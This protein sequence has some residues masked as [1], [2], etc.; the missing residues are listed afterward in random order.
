[1]KNTQQTLAVDYSL[2]DK[3][4]SFM[5]GIFKKFVYRGLPKIL[6]TDF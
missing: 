2:L 5:L 3:E 6:K 4:N 1:M